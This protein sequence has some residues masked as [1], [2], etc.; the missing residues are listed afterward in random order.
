M[1]DS[2]AQGQK[3]E[4]IAWTN[5]AQ[6]SYLKHPGYAEIPM[7]MWGKRND[8]SANVPLYVAPLAEGAPRSADVRAAKPEARHDRRVL[9]MCQCC[10]EDEPDGAVCRR[11]DI[12]VMPD[13]TWLCD[14]CY[15]DC[16]KTAY[17]LIPSAVEDFEFP[18]FEDLPRPA[19]YAETSL[20]SPAENDAEALLLK[21]DVA[22]FTEG[23]MHE[24][25]RAAKDYVAKRRA[26]L[27]STN[28]PSTERA[29]GE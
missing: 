18:G 13:G 22:S 7:A 20:H 15:A 17:G 24:A 21:I 5:E 29:D 1:T 26:A 16:E 9:F 3:S 12:A 19:P 27:T 4:P 6:L 28:R 10:E 11:E 14:S 25:I 2:H 23:T 8:V